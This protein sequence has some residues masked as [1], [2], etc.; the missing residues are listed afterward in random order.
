MVSPLGVAGGGA[1]GGP[2]GGASIFG[3]RRDRFELG[4]D[5]PFDAGG[6]EG[7][8]LDP[9]PWKEVADTLLSAEIGLATSSPNDP[10]DLVSCM[11]LGPGTGK[12]TSFDKSAES[13]LARGRPSKLLLPVRW[14]MGDRTSSGMVSAEDRRPYISLTGAN[15]AFINSSCSDCSMTGVRGAG[16]IPP[17]L[18]R[19]FVR[20]GGGRELDEVG[21]SKVE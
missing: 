17:L 20:G 12:G 8:S 19:R 6:D 18:P 7:G 21:R 16:G 5:G 1:G 11:P 3:T 9:L 10:L 14:L 2:D 13:R 4:D 15:M